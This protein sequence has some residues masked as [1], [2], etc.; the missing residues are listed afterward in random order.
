MSVTHEVFVDGR[1]SEQEIT[2]IILADSDI[3]MV[4]LNSSKKMS[5][6]EKSFLD[7]FV[8]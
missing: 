8:K 4:G 7:I 5:A 6:L 3:D 1:A 2:R